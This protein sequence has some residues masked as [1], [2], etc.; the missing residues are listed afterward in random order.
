MIGTVGSM[1]SF[2]EGSQLLRELAGIDID[3]SQVER[4]SEALGGEIAADERRH[5]G[6]LEEQPFGCQAPPCR[7]PSG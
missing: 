1:V 5:T 4:G 7:G 3:A 6:P 2:Q